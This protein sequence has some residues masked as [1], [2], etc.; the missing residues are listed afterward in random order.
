MARVTVEDC[1]DKVENRFE[2]VALAAQR[3]KDI[4][5]GINITVDREDDKDS[6]VALR[7]I[8]NANI[9][10]TI[11]REELIKRLQ[12]R[13]KIDHIDDDQPTVENSED[14]E[15]VA[16]SD[17]YIEDADSGYEEQMFSD[18]VSDIDIED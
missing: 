16:D 5:S 3:T 15:Y 4:S 2:L 6:V 13:N 8:A 11:L 12:T 18:D 9:K 17:F 14:F 1:I 7:E 10:P